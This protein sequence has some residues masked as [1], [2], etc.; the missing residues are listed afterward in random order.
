MRAVTAVVL[1]LL[2]G[3][4]ATRSTHVAP[5]DPT[6]R[7]LSCPSGTVAVYAGNEF[8]RRFD[9]CAHRSELQFLVR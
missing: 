8:E 7:K 2:V 4:A 3:C 9:G 6:V 1:L 5:F